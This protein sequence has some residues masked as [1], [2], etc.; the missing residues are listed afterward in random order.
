M[1]KC[2][3]RDSKC[4]LEKLKVFT[5]ANKNLFIKVSTSDEG[6]D[7]NFARRP[8]R[9]DVSTAH[10]RT[11][12]PQVLAG[13]CSYC[14][15]ISEVHHYLLA[16]STGVFHPGMTAKIRSRSLVRL[17]SLSDE[18]KGVEVERKF[19]VHSCSCCCLRDDDASR[20]CIFW[21]AAKLQL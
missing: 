9:V 13:P 16:P 17:H 11:D 4:R 14:R 10:L 2:T 3:S 20:G 8:G 18:K 12:W 21:Q 15:D 6:Q 5:C 1:A 7:W 19:G